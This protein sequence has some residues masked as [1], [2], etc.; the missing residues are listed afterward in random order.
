[1]NPF[2]SHILGIF[3]DMWSAINWNGTINDH[4]VE[5]SKPSDID[6]CS[7]FESL[8]NPEGVTNCDYV[9]NSNLYI[10]ILDDPIS[11][12]EV[13][14]CIHKLK[15][16]KAA[17]IDG[18]SPGLLKLLPD[19]WIILLTYVFNLV[20]LADYPMNWTLLKVFTIHKKGPHQDPN[21]YRGI[22]VLSALP[23]VYDMILS[24]RFALWYAPRCEQAGAQPRRGCEEQILTLRLLIDI[25]RKTKR[26][27][28]IT[29]IDYQKA[30]DRV[31][32]RKLLQYL[33]G[34]GCGATFLKALKNSMT[35]SGQ[36][37]SS[38]FN[39]SAGVKQGGP[40]SCMLFTAYIDPTI[41]VLRNFGPDD[42]LENTHILL[43]MDDTVLFA[44][45]RDMMISK[46]R[47]LKDK[48]DEIG[49]LFH[50]TKC[51]YMA[52]NSA[53]AEPM[54]MDDITIG[55]TESYTYLG[56]TVSNNNIATQVK[57][58]MKQKQTHVR[59]FTSFCTKNSD[60][61]YRVK[62]RVWTSALNSALLYSC[63]TW[64][65]ADLRAVESSFMNSLKLM[66]SVRQTTCNDLVHIETGIPNAKSV[67]VDRQRAYFRKLR[68]NHTNDYIANTIEM[69]I[70]LRT[71][72][73][74][75]IQQISSPEHVE[76]QE[77]TVFFDNLKSRV[78][79]S[80]STRRK[81]YTSLN[82]NYEPSLFLSLQ[83]G[84]PIPEQRLVSVH[85]LR[86]GSHHLR[87]ETGR[88][89]RTPAEER[90]CHCG[91]YIQDEKHVLLE[92]QFSSDFRRN[93][94]VNYATLEELF[95]QT[96]ERLPIIAEYCDLVF[97]LYRT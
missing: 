50:Q 59:K 90:V 47:L 40:A 46:L 33:E 68:A 58:H 41:D 16:N 6:F 7:H 65:T 4:H 73:G 1:M 20:F 89:S 72:M 13:N 27:L 29:Y 54:I 45:S 39:T 25:A 12:D 75:R 83:P 96:A 78:R 52:I 3:S 37:G 8:L 95:N 19:N 23:K 11:P 36:I 91:P 76:T 80:P 32:R 15:P 88:W 87:V 92:C 62:H 82:P 22:S 53:D 21:N 44:S 38:T 85:R 66:L 10:P 31:D 49:M 28:Y 63:E 94:N 5:N 14:T 64:L 97:K 70:R 55:R 18:I 51:Q 93:M 26:Q 81:S 43:L 60:S 57:I 9:P 30:Y 74:K 34:K 24:C 77:T 48:T 86:L 42:W 79:L 56:A 67:I 35:A 2:V 71:P 61:P 84:V 69:A 17:G